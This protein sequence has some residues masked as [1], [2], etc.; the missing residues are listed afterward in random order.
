VEPKRSS[1]FFSTETSSSETQVKLAPYDSIPIE[2]SLE[3]ILE[4]L[5]G[6]NLNFLKVGD[7]LYQHYGPLARS[8]AN[9]M[10]QEYLWVM[11][12]SGMLD[13]SKQEGPTPD[14]FG[15]LALPVV[16]YNDEKLGKKL[17]PFAPGETWR[18][19]RMI[20]QKHIF[21]STDAASHV[22]NINTVS[23]RIGEVFEEKMSQRMEESLFISECTL[24][25]IYAILF[26]L[27]PGILD[28]TATDAERNFI[29]NTLALNRVAGEIIQNAEQFQKLLNEGTSEKYLQFEKIFDELIEHG[30]SVCEKVASKLKDGSADNLIR[31]SYVARQYLDNPNA[32]FHELSVNA[33]VLLTAGVD[34]TSSIIRMMLT[35][36]AE[37]PEY[38]EDMLKQMQEIR[39]DR[40]NFDFHFEDR[41]KHHV[42][43]SMI[44]EIGRLT[45]VVG[46]FIRRLK[47]PISID[48]YEIPAETM[49]F[50]LPTRDQNTK[51]VWDDFSE[52]N[53]SRWYS[54][55]AGRKN[56]NK[57]L[58]MKWTSS[59]VATF[60]RGNRKCL[61]FRVA[62]SEVMS[63]F[64]AVIPKYKLKAT[65]DP[66][67]PPYEY[68]MENGLGSYINIPKIEVEKR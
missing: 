59:A 17:W 4:Y 22:D 5:E 67:L 27:N 48:G 61:G 65:W 58:S 43:N 34:T 63:F 53:P 36:L 1:L 32:D 49:M 11:S 37:A 57:E 35:R 42:L 55:S 13:L 47:H 2:T 20:A 18:E 68:N 66:K 21:G 9:V 14:G 64:S 28:G 16:K 10:G 46:G 33:A 12:R 50:C 45:P 19:R 7:Y 44:R 62:E 40:P 23:R 38:Q 60:G 54:I 29:K 31:G 56:V 39:G 6:K 51:E 52:F 8:G 41:E 24:E 30:V 3:P 26:G 15:V 25:Y